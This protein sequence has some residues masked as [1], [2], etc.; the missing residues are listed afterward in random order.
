MTIPWTGAPATFVFCEFTKKIVFAQSFSNTFLK[1]LTS[2]YIPYPFEAIR[3][4]TLLKLKE[5]ATIYVPVLDCLS[6]TVNVQP[7]ETQPSP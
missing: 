5:R 6:D 2:Q 3:F 4:V 7:I 1:Y